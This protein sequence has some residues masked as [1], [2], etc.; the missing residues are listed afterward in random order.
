[1]P[2]NRGNGALAGVVL[3]RL[4]LAPPA[5]VSGGAYCQ[6]GPA[7][8]GE[9]EAGGGV[10]QVGDQRGGCGGHGTPGGGGGEYLPDR[11]VLG[12]Q[13]Q[14]GEVGRG[15]A[16]RQGRDERDPQPGGDE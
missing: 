14:Q 15:R 8:L 9:L 3:D 6:G 16:D 7:A 11:G 2:A 5:R 1:M 13:P 4:L 12:V 10:A